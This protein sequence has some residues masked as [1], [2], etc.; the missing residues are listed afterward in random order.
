MKHVVFESK[1]KN[2]TQ[3]LFI[4]IP[5]ASVMSFEFDFRAGEYLMPKPKFEVPHIMEHLLLGANKLIPRSRDFQAE[6]EKNGAYCNASTGTYDVSYEAE[7]ADFEWDRIVSLLLVAITQP[8]FLEDEFAAESGNVREELISRSNNHFRHLSLALRKSYGFYS[9]TDQER[10]ELMHNVELADISKHYDRTHT[11]SNMRFVIAG[12]L[13]RARRE[14]I[15]E[16][17]EKMFLPRG[18]GR[19]DLPPEVPHGLV[20]PLYIPNDTVK[21]LYFYIDTFLLRRL[22]NPEIDALQLFNIMMTETLYSKILGTARERGLVYAMSSGFGQ[23]REA[24]NWWLGTQV[25]VKNAPLLFEIIASELKSVLRGSLS[26]GDIKSSQQYALGRYQ[27]SGQTVSGTAAGYSSRYFFDGVVDDYYK[28]PERIKAVS[29][30]SIAAITKNLFS[31]K[32][33]G[34]GMLG[35]C[36]DDLIKELQASVQPLWE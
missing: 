19:L 10:L 1:L 2:Q 27:R 11:T 12:K 7:C 24:S 18:D 5:D 22:K 34:L 26:V 3:G 13:P 4:H 14:Q 20:K 9:L 32:L 21:N 35:E 23:T 29:K 31:D 6:F 36:N 25:S 8:L 28:I 33:W 30:P 17:I 16:Q 15:E